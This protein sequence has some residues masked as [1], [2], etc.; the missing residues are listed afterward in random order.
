MGASQPVPDKWEPFQ[1]QFSDSAPE[2]PPTFRRCTKARLV[3]RHQ[4]FEFFKPVED[5]DQF[6]GHHILFA[7]DHQE[8]L[9][10]G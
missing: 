2:V 4:P 5:D 9:P 10:I 8:T 1:D 7:L 6:R 3:C